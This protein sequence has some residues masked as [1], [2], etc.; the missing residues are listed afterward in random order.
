MRWPGPAGVDAAW[1]RALGAALQEA[2]W[3]EPKR[4]Q[5]WLPS[6][7]FSSLISTAAA[8]FKREETLVE[9][10]RLRARRLPALTRARPAPPARWRKGDGGG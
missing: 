10:R 2:S 3:A 6:P 7:V 4:L 9:V 1:C 8:L 5:R